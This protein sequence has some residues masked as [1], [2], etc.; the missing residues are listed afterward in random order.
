V[1]SPGTPELLTTHSTPDAGPKDHP[2]HEP[3][4]PE[5]DREPALVAMLAEAERKVE[6]VLEDMPGAFVDSRRLIGRELWPLPRPEELQTIIKIAADK[7]AEGPRRDLPR[8]FLALRLVAE[9]L[10]R[11]YW[12]PML[13]DPGS[14]WCRA[15][16]LRTV[17][18]AVARL[19]GLL[20]PGPRG[21]SEVAFEDRVY[22]KTVAHALAPRRDLIGAAITLAHP[23]IEIMEVAGADDLRERV[24]S[25]T[26]TEADLLRRTAAIA[27]GLEDPAAPMA[28][29]EPAEGMEDGGSEPIEDPGGD[30]ARRHVGIEVLT[31]RWLIHGDVAEWEELFL[32]AA[33]SQSETTAPGEENATGATGSTGATA[34][35]LAPSAG[36]RDPSASLAAPGNGEDDAIWVL[37]ED[38]CASQSDAPD[39]PE[40]TDAPSG[41]PEGDLT[42]P[43]SV[44]SRTVH[45]TAEQV[46]RRVQIHKRALQHQVLYG[47]VSERLQKIQ[48]EALLMRQKETTEWLAAFRRP[49]VASYSRLLTV[50]RNQVPGAPAPETLVAPDDEP[51]E[52]FD[53]IFEKAVTDV[54]DK[55]AAEEAEKTAMPGRR[56]RKAR[57][58]RIALMGVIILGLGAVAVVVHFLIPKP[59]PAALVFSP[60]EARNVISL[61]ETRPIG[62]MLY[63]KLSGEWDPFSVEECEREVV[64][65]SRIALERGFTS[66][67]LV[68]E[69]GE[70]L[71]QWDQANGPKIFTPPQSQVLGP[72]VSR[73]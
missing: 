63:A 36:S 60:S 41:L 12:D 54:A 50:V 40:E 23:L 72:K 52:T 2:S 18:E 48:D 24:P 39:S 46:E 38:T 68:D 66:I 14:I 47:V 31:V 56:E 5:L 43:A 29:A 35:Q 34:P 15:E 42:G 21:A 59:P 19:E 25:M 26:Q 45:L 16:D 44:P 58:R 20:E 30:P 37:D 64:S 9:E 49:L 13:L 6:R 61:S 17:L 51:S 53:E 28:G 22:I 10:T 11:A 4:L 62:T 7:S 70:P 73:P 33:R 65:L 55:K 8:R 3:A 27:G 67:Y 69:S 57:L 32:E 71:A 1:A